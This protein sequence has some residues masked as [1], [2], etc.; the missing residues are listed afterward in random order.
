MHGL[1]PDAQVQLTAKRASGGWE[2]VGERSSP[3][4]YLDELVAEQK[5]REHQKLIRRWT[6]GRRPT[7]ILKTD[8]FEE[9][10]G[11]DQILFDLFDDTTLTIGMDV[12]FATVSKARERC[13]RPAVTFCA[14]DARRLPI[15]SNSIGL[16]LSTSTLDHFDT[17]AEFEQSLAELVR[18]LRP[19]G[20]LIITLD[21]AYNPW[22]YPLRWV[23]R[24][25]SA[26]FPLGYTAPLGELKR[27]LQA[28]GLAIVDS[29]TLIHNPRLVSSGIFTG[30]RMALGRFAD[31]P[32]RALLW[33]F[34]LG[35][36]LPT[37][38]ISGCFIAVRAAKADAT[39]PET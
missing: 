7:G 15:R 2:D 31:F 13:P 3:S 18:I 12:S 9:A 28:L 38:W 35:D 26:P 34:A 32:I 16:I 23:S 17:R 22:Y 11:S 14:A 37:R 33:L 36:H 4:W 6:A 1:T 20:E 5:R 10:H 39:G 27:Q 21:N 24:R 8:V 25:G 19:G 30:L 29:E